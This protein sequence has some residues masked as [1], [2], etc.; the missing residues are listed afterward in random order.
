LRRC[1]RRTRRRRHRSDGRERLEGYLHLDVGLLRNPLIGMS[2][3][4]PL[5]TAALAAFIPQLGAT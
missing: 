4:T 3:L 5:I 1:L 2:I